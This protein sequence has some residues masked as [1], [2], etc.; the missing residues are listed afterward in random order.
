MENTAETGSQG[1][2]AIAQRV[3]LGLDRL[4]RLQEE[5]NRQIQETALQMKE[6]DRQLRERMQETDRQLRERIQE[7]ALQMKETDRQLKETDRQLRE[8]MQ[9]T[10]RQ[11]KETVLQ[12]K[13][14]DRQM[15]ETDR[16]MKETDLKIGKL[17]KNIG[18][19]N[20][21]FGALIENL[22]SARLWE[23]F[24]DYPYNLQRA[25][26]RVKLYDENNRVRTDIDILLSDGTYAMAVEVK[27]K[28]DKESDVEHHMKRMELIKKYPPAEVKGK[29]LLGAMAGGEVDADVANFAHAN[30][31]FVLELAGE[32]VRLVSP[33]SDFTPRK[34]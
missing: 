15:K 24:A 11:M 25:Y 20:N 5:T 30:G 3:W 1:W 8:R 7:T 23:K 21:S 31:F 28:L 9:E 2:E 22:I 17:S 34:W 16:Q 27:E 14:T 29:F 10:D 4:E 19:L 32:A 6:T 26:Q 12:M 13:E 33:P 18:G